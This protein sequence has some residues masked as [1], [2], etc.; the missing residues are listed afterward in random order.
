VLALGHALQRSAEPGRKGDREDGAACHLDDIV[1]ATARAPRAAH[2][3]RGGGS[4]AGPACLPHRARA[5]RAMRTPAGR[6]R[7]PGLSP[8]DAVALAGSGR[9]GET[10]AA[11][12]DCTNRGADVALG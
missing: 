6:F 8:A 12:A 11:A 4:P 2:S 9:E 1:A 10:W 7:L 5:A 3:L